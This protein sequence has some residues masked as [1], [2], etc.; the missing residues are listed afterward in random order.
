MTHEINIRNVFFW[1]NILFVVHLMAVL[2]SS[3]T[4]GIIMLSSSD[5]QRN[6]FIQM[7]ERNLYVSTP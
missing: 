5:K 2:L 4:G 6:T 1:D 7:Q 3:L